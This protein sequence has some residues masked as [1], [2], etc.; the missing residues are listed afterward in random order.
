MNYDLICK[1]A[2]DLGIKLFPEET[3]IVGDFYLAHRN[4]PVK[5]LQVKEI[6]NGYIV[7]VEQDYCYD[8][9]ECIKTKIT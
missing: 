5:L 2:Q 1:E 9:H 3:L 7:P 8:K 4:G 6:K